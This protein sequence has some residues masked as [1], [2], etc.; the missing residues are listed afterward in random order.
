MNLSELFDAMVERKKVTF[1]NPATKR[2]NTGKIRYVGIF[3]SR[4][5]NLKHYNYLAHN[6]DI[7]K[8]D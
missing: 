6:C 7:T 1:I 8:K 3:F 4:V 5:S 2:K